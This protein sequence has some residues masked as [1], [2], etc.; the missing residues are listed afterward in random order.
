MTSDTI[1]LYFTYAIAVL[2]LLGTF[3]LLIW[4]SQVPAEQLLPF[5]TGIVGIVIGFVFNREST[6]SGARA[7]ER[8]VA[9]GASGGAQQGGG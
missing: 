1:R 8:A 4:P 5:L 3:L 9:Q 2:V 7:S 6:T